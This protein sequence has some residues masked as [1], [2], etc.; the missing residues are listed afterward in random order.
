M[1]YN[2]F[3]D[4]YYPAPAALAQAKPRPFP[5]V[6]RKFPQSD[7]AEIA[8][9]SSLLVYGEKTW[10]LVSNVLEPKHFILDERAKVFEII[11]A[12]HASGHAADLIAVKSAIANDELFLHVGGA[13]FV[14][15]MA[16]ISVPPINAEQYAV[17]VRKLYLQREMIAAFEYLQNIGYNAGPEETEAVLA[18][19]FTKAGRA[20]SK[21]CLNRKAHDKDAIEIAFTND[22]RPILDS[23]WTIKEFLPASGLVV[24]Y[25]E[26]GCGKTFVVLD[27][28]MATAR[29]I[30]WRGKKTKKANV[31][32]IAPDGGALIYNRIAAYKKHTTA[33]N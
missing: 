12:L 1:A 30:A 28:C 15:E 23:L 10:K 5:H 7:E 11:A 33:S 3:G 17:L 21:M 13:K 19:Y 16:D 29:D 24:V 22:R 20:F 8:V 27:F 18:E 2:D 4:P 9:T 14:D 25:G 6:N 31:L 26:P 32:Y